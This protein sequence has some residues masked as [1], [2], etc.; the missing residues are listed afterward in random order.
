[1]DG[2]EIVPSPREQD[3][4]RKERHN[5][6]LGTDVEVHYVAPKINGIEATY[7]EGVGFGVSDTK[8]MVLNSNVGEGT[9]VKD[10]MQVVSVDSGSGPQSPKPK[11]T[12]TR[13]RCMEIRPMELIKEGAKS[14]LGK[15]SRSREGSNLVEDEQ[16][17]VVKRGKSSADTSSEET[18]GVLMHPCGTQ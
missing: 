4:L 18:A 6:K 16:I 13:L 1:M 9:K 3:E 12:W 8:I 14:V 2:E 7:K 10:L 17:E 11:A 15:Q 5:G